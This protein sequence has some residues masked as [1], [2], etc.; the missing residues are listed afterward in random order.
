MIEIRESAALQIRK[1]LAKQQMEE[2]GLRIGLK[3]GGCSGFE[4][5]FAWEQA[6]HEG[7]HVFE[8][9]RS[10]GRCNMSSKWEASWC[11]DEGRG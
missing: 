9:V 7:D 11:S 5:V 3:S 10:T 8:G 2:G 6:P 4:Y 1:L